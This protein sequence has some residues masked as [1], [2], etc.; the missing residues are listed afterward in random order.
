MMTILPLASGAAESHE[1]ARQ[2]SGRKNVRLE[3]TRLGRA[4][5]IVGAFILGAVVAALVLLALVPQ[6]SAEDVPQTVTVRSGDTLWQIAEEHAPEDA[7]LTRY[8]QEAQRINNLSTQRVTE[9]QE[10]QL[11]ED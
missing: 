2:P 11:P 6:A 1:A 8:V 4:L 7:D 5:I 9:G 3:P 10:L